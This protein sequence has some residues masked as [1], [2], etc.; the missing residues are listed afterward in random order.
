MKDDRMEHHG[1]HFRD[2]LLNTHNQLNPED[3]VDVDFSEE[4]GNDL[5][6]EVSGALEDGDPHRYDGYDPSAHLLYLPA[7][8]DRHDRVLLVIYHSELLLR[9]TQT[10]PWD[11][12]KFIHV[13]QARMNYQDRSAKYAEV[14]VNWRMTRNRKRKRI[15]RMVH[16][17]DSNKSLNVFHMTVI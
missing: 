10:R 13:I 5:F 2:L 11:L 7:H 16:E 17:W 8:R 1:R 6:M 15:V 4:P 14:A 12:A 9:L 3:R